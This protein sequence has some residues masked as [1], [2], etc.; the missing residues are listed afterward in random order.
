LRRASDDGGFTRRQQTAR[1]RLGKRSAGPAPTR[2]ALIAERVDALLAQPL[3][4]DAPCS[5]PC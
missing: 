3:T 5:F 4:M 1:E 2:S